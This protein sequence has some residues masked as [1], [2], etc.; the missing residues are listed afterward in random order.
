MNK[1]FRSALP[2]K[3]LVLVPPVQH[4]KL[5]RLPIKLNQTTNPHNQLGTMD[6]LQKKAG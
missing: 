2:D 3:L 5:T 1:T 4:T 6:F